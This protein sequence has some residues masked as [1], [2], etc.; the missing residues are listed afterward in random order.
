M[1]GRILSEFV[2]QRSY[3]KKIKYILLL[4]LISTSVYSQEVGLGPAKIW[5][6]NY[7]IQNPMGYGIFL[8]QHIGRVA[9]RLEYVSADNER[10]YFG[11]LNG[12]FIAHQ[13]DII[14]ESIFSSSSFRAVEISLQIPRIYSLIKNDFNA[15][16]G[17][18]FDKFNREKTGMTSLKRYETTENKFGFFYSVSLSRNNILGLPIKIE[19]LFKQKWLM[20]GSYAT[21][22]E[23]PFAAAIDIKELQLNFAYLFRFV[24]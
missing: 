20:R 21:D 17:I 15:G 3:V 23:Q 5:T 11:V 12:G 1:F 19:L 7:E 8:Y 22:I 18:T 4:I 14:Q 9:L 13:E 10:K 24:E 2:L 6:N 16:I